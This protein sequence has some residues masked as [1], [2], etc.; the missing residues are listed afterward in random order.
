MACFCSIAKLCPILWHPMNCI[1][2]GSP[3]LNYLLEFSQIHVPWSVMLSKHLILCH[4]LFLLPSNFPSSKVFSAKSPL[5]IRWPKYWSFS[6]SNEYSLL[7][8]F[9]IDWFD[10]LAIQGTLKSLLQHHSAKASLLQWS[11]F[12]IVKLSHQYTTTGKT[13]ALTGP[14]LAKWCLWFLICCLASS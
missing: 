2:S 7:I 5:C 3:V 13:T 1:T 8:S 12:F 10:I 14:L 9:R 6:P 4:L 11:A